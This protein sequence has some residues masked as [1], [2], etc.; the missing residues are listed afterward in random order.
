MMKLSIYLK[1]SQTKYNRDICTSVSLC[2]TFSQQ[3]SYRAKVGNGSTEKQ[4]RKM[5]FIYIKEFFSSL[6]GMKL[7]HL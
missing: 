7:V 2:S 3:L 4:M 6:K 5:W 1:D